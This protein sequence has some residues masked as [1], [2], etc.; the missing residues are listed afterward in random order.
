M[1]ETLLLKI[2]AGVF[3]MLLIGIALTV[4]E[5]HRAGCEPVEKSR[6]SAGRKE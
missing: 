6:Q 3:L 4:Y 2:A 1:S 5:F